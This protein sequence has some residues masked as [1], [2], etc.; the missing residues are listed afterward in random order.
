M[1]REEFWL[2]KVKEI[3]MSDCLISIQARVDYINTLEGLTIDLEDESDEYC[4][5]EDN[6]VFYINS[7]F[8]RNIS[9]IEFEPN[10]CCEASECSDGTIDVNVGFYNGG[11]GL[12]EM[13][14]EA[15]NNLQPHVSNKDLSN[16]SACL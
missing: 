12:D 9:L 8:Y 10:E 4:H 11:A 15:F 16:N 1:S 5:S 13:L 14:D 6:S 7:K 3:V 2:G